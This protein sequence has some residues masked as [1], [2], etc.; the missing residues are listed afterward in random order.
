[1][2]LGARAAAARPPLS[3][4]LSPAAAAGA[5]APPRSLTAACASDTATP[6]LLYC[7]ERV[8]ALVRRRA[9]V[10]WYEKFGVEADDLRA[11]A[12]ALLDTVDAY[13]AARR[14]VG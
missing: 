1:M 8:D 4:V 9:Y 6:R 3:A 11:A 7:V 12:E 13:A 5:A 10:H 14:E 2:H